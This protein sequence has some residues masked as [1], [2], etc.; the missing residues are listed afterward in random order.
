VKFYTD[1]IQC[2][3]SIVI[4][5]FCYDLLKT[6]WQTEWRKWCSSR[7]GIVCPVLFVH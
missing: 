2:H 6:I 7:V 1:H 3:I 5:V 4:Y